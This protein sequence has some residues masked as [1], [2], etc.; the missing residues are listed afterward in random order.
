MKQKHVC[1]AI[2]FLF[3]SACGW[4]FP[5][6]DDAGPTGVR[7]VVRHLSNAPA[8]GIR[9]FL[10]PVDDDWSD[11]GAEVA[12]L[13]ENLRRVVTTGQDGSYRLEAPERGLY[14]VVA[15]YDGH[16]TFPASGSTLV[17]GSSETLTH[18]FR[19]LPFP[20]EVIPISAVQGTGHQSPV[21]GETVDLVVGVVTMVR[22][23]LG[24]PWQS[25]RLQAV[26]L[27]DPNP[28]GKF[29]SSDALK[30]LMPEWDLVEPGQ[31]V[32]VSN[33]RVV[34]DV[35]DPPFYDSVWT[36][37]SLSRTQLH[38]DATHQMHVWYRPTTGRPPVV[39]PPV[40]IGAS[41]VLPPGIQSYLGIGGRS[42]WDEDVRIQ[43]A[44]R[45]L[46]FYEGL[47]HMRVE[48]VDPLVTGASDQFGRIFVTPDYAA[49]AVDR[50]SG[51]G[52]RNA[53][54]HRFDTALEILP[55]HSSAMPGIPVGTRFDAAVTGVL[56][57]HRGRYS[58]LSDSVHTLPY[59]LLPPELRTVPPPGPHD[60]DIAALNVYNLSNSGTSDARFDA[61]AESIVD[62]LAS[63]AVLLLVEVLDDRGTANG[64]N[65]DATVTLERLRDAVV[66]AGGPE[67]GWQQIDPEVLSDGG[68]P[69]GNPR[70]VAFYDP[71][72]TAP[73]Y[74]GEADSADHA[75]E[76]TTGLYTA[77]DGAPVLVR[78]LPS[79]ITG[80]HDTVFANSRKPLVTAFTM[81][82]HTLYLIGVHFTSKIGDTPVFGR[83]QPPDRSTSEEARRH[84]QA[85]AVADFVDELL[86]LDPDAY[87]IVAGDLND[88]EY[89]QTAAILEHAGLINLMASVAAEDR[90]TYVFH[91][92][93]Q[94]LDQILATEALLSDFVHEFRVVHR[95]TA[96]PYTDSRR[97][98][99]HEPVHLRLVGALQ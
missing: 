37:S 99:D 77:S 98:S 29:R 67:Y 87:V 38:L 53:S 36:S 19:V 64:S 60:F 71:V 48:I 92:Y 84:P 43:P 25:P 65:P 68:V 17:H 95:H 63:P 52:L 97:A 23:N 3:V 18:D 20:D 1:I 42:L 51:G 83:I 12:E 34:E 90:Y 16:Y 96:W 66:A 46:D 11:V 93:G 89:S 27:Q 22:R 81:G 74:A 55:V 76:A 8:A 30:I 6:A 72:R 73:V 10:L 56:D 26:Y 62:G 54:Y 50:R 61:L 45:A 39:P 7:G 59:R 24:I 28:D 82:E 47:E 44:H 79:R 4:L 13:P 57:Y 85:Q 9:V 91:G 21:Q 88:F 78:D 70:V 2:L 33:A 5:Q 31:V 94:V 35:R 40:R 58:V 15:E 14:R 49:D 41:G 86:V 32:A 75:T 80:A 69:D